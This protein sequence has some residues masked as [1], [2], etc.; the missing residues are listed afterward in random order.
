MPSNIIVSNL[1]PETVKVPNPPAGQP[2]I[3][4]KA[5][6]RDGS[7]PS[8]QAP[9]GEYVP[10]GQPGGTIDPAFSI[11]NFVYQGA[12]KYQLDDAVSK[13]GYNRGAF[14]YRAPNGSNGANGSFFADSIYGSAV[15][16]FQI[17][18]S[19][20]MATDR[21]SLPSASVLQGFV[22]IKPKAGTPES[23]PNN[24]IGW[25]HMIDG[26][27]WISMH[28]L[29]GGNS[30]R[31]LIAL[32]DPASLASSTAYGFFGIEGGGLTLNYCSELPAE[33]QTVF[34]ATHLVGNC[35][36]MSIAPRSSQGP[37]LLTFDKASYTGSHTL[38]PTTMEMGWPYKAID[39][40]AM[41][42]TLYP[43]PA[44]E[45]YADNHWDSYNEGVSLH[46]YRDQLGFS[47]YE[48][49][50]TSS[51][52]TEWKDLPRPAE[53]LR[54]DLNSLINGGWIGFVVPNTDTF[55]V[56]GFQTGN[57]F[58]NGYKKNNFQGTLPN[59][60]GGN[61]FDQYDQDWYYWAFNLNDVT[62]IS[63]I[64][65][66]LPFEYGRFD[67]NRWFNKGGNILTIGDKPGGG[68]FDPATNRL[69]V[70]VPSGNE[71]P[72]IVA[73]YQLGGV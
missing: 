7:R 5:E 65:N 50:R 73:V 59:N 34:N 61:A 24:A 58:G 36:G 60:N 63:N 20:S 38:I 9:S 10:F 54:N 31:S 64:Y 23:D 40:R 67:D 47:T 53:S 19:F 22:N 33:Y 41:G 11:D 12:F 32:N 43:A 56:I 26:K 72:N 27:L 48:E 8:S 30:D 6:L 68:H 25:M 51:P 46:Y 2:V 1:T 52:R 71:E 14:G 18:A 55:L 13:T 35:F 49:W 37:S 42:D 45:F 66:L 3:A 15:A 57:E 62:T 28:Y 29:Y 17:P 69:Y 70:S 39:G 44:G 4:T 21:A 16:E